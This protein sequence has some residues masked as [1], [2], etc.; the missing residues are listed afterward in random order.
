MS[1][2]VLA[3]ILVAGSAATLEAVT[4]G[5]PADVGEYPA[6]VALLQPEAWPTTSRPSSAAAP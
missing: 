1:V 5:R 4:R 3:A 2:L 6:Q